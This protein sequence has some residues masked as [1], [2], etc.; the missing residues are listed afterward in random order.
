MRPAFNLEP[1]YGVTL[2]TREDWTNGTG[3]PSAVK[4]LVWFTDGSRMGRR[5]G[6]GV[7]GQY[8]GRRFSFSLGRYMKVFQAEIFAILSCAYEIH[9]RHR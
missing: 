6:D 5:V 9:N 3:V 4:E 7:Y 2:L 8:V 1:K